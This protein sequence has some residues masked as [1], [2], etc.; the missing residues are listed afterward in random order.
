MASPRDRV[1]PNAVFPPKPVDTSGQQSPAASQDTAQNIRNMQLMAAGD[2]S[3]I[4]ILYGGPERMGG[5]LYTL[6]IPTTGVYAGCLVYSLLMMDGV[7][8]SLTDFEVNNA[9][10]PSGIT[11][12]A[13]N[14]SQVIVDPALAA[15]MPGFTETMNGT[16][17]LS[18]VVGP[19]AVQGWP[20]IT[21]MVKGRKVYDPRTTLTVW[22]DN[23]ALCIRDFLVNFC[24]R[25]VSEPHAIS[26]ADWCDVNL[27]NGTTTIKRSTMTLLLDTNRTVDSWLD[28]MRQYLPGWIV[29][30][31]GLARIV[32]DRDEASSHTFTVDNVALR[33]FPQVSMRGIR[34]LPTRVDVGYTDTTQVPWRVRYASAGSGAARTRIELPGL[35]TFSAAKRFATERLNHYRIENNEIAFGVFDYG[36]RILPGDLATITEPTYGWTAEPIRILA[37]KDLGN[38]RWTV[39]ARIYR[40]AAYSGVVVDPTSWLAGSLPDPRTVLPVTG[41]SALEEVFLESSMGDDYLARAYI[42][43]SRLKVLWTAPTDSY[44]RDYLVR[45]LDGVNTV[46]EAFVRFPEI[47]TPIVQQGVTYTVE[48]YTRNTYGYLSAKQTVVVLALGKLLPP[49]DVPSITEAR[50]IGGDVLVAI[51]PA[52]DID[53]VRYEWRVGVDSIV[54][55]WEDMPDDPPLD[56]V[57]GL[58]ARFFA[59]PVGTHRLAVK[60]IDSVGNYSINATYVVV[61]VTSDSEAFIQDLTASTMQTSRALRFDAPLVEGES[62]TLQPRWV[63]HSK[64]ALQIPTSSSGVIPAS[65]PD[66]ASLDIVGDIDIRLDVYITLGP[67]IKTILSKWSPGYLFA[68]D[69]AGALFFYWNNGATLNA[70]STANIPGSGRRRIRVTMDVNNGAA[71]RDIKFYTAVN[72]GTPL[73]AATWVQL[74]ATVT[75]AGVTTIGAG[76]AALTLGCQN[77]AGVNALNAEDRIYE[78]VVYDGIAGTMVVR[79]IPDDWPLGSTSFPDFSGKTWTINAPAKLSPMPIGEALPS[80]M[81]A[82]NV[83]AMFRYDREVSSFVLTGVHDLGSMMT[84]VFKWTNPPVVHTGPI[85]NF[86]RVWDTGMTNMRDTLVNSGNGHSTQQT[87]RYVQVYTYFATPDGSYMQ[88]GWPKLQVTAETSTESGGPIAS[89]ASGGKLVELN[90]QYFVAD[91]IQIT[92]LGTAARTYSVDN[93]LVHRESGL[94]Y[95]YEFSGVGNNQGQMRIYAPSVGTG[96]QVATGDVVEFEVY[97]DPSSP[98]TTNF[99]PGGDILLIYEDA[100]ST[101]GSLVDQNGHS[102]WAMPLAAR[103]LANG[104]WYARTTQGGSSIPV[105]DNG[106]RI[107]SI[108]IGGNG[109]AASGTV[110][111][112]YRNIRIRRAGSVV[113]TAYATSGAPLAKTFINT[114]TANGRGGPANS[115][116]TYIFTTAGAQVVNNF[117]YNF[118]GVAG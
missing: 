15:A 9:A 33:P 48:V 90:N 81:S 78:A 101:G 75:Q 13:Y 25:A 41:L 2:N 45:V 16:A 67:A 12:V 52:V 113:F 7:A 115:F 110:Q 22:S 65:T 70:F 61:T 118:K 79:F 112:L 51:E 72:D 36:V 106:K 109:D 86:I 1:I 28:V 43:Q 93:V 82:G 40:V 26:A 34:D 95:S 102:M 105:G 100:T 49:G 31:E 80:P 58:R 62:I 29:T 73:S 116:E 111:M 53:I 89:L 38:G 3:L 21:A 6:A 83:D 4:P 71:G 57:D 107:G 76:A 42:Y 23:T 91:S 17:Y 114:L 55:T 14:G 77:A 104:Q 8:E 97:I 59:L 85:S 54:A 46:H 64:L 117:M 103:P 96:F 99:S 44:L 50:E 35:R 92:P 5:L 18:V 87:C 47:S 63:P 19:G 74:G 69:P 68:V 60:A 88:Q 32:P 37:V 66:H 30:S 27:T 11:I 10:V 108:Q 56:R 39:R 84:A 20:N 94:Y 24:G 98:T